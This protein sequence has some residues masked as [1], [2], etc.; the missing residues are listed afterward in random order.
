M[1]SENPVLFLSAFNTGACMKCCYTE[2]LFVVLPKH[3]LFK[4]VYFIL[5]KCKNGASV[6]QR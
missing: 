2:M 1:V 5:A 3:T 4:V 6:A